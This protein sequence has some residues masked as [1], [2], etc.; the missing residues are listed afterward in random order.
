VRSRVET[1]YRDV[2]R[3]ADGSTTGFLQILVA[4]AQKNTFQRII[5][6]PIYPVPAKSAGLHLA[7]DQFLEMI[8]CSGAHVPTLLARI[9]LSVRQL[10]ERK[11]TGTF[12]TAASVAE[13][14]LAKGLLTSSDDVCDAGAGTGV[15]ADAILRNGQPIRSYVGVENDPVLALCAAHALEALNAPECYKLWYANFLL[16]G[17]TDFTA[18]GLAVPTAVIANP[19]FVRS[20]N[21]TGRARIRAAL[22]SS[23]GVSVPSLAGS[24]SYFISRAADL[25]GASTSVES[26]PKSRLLFFL[27]K[28]AA[29]AA[30]VQQ[31][32]DDLRR[33]HGWACRQFEIPNKQTGV[34]RHASNSLALFFLLEQVPPATAPR[35]RKSAPR[36]CLQDVVRIKRGISTGFNDFFVLTDEEVKRRKI[37]KKRL[38][39]VLPTRISIKTKRF[40]K[41]DWD[42]LRLSN[43]PCWLL[44]LP[45]G[46]IEN[47]EQAI[48]EYLKEGLRRGVHETPTAKAY[49]T[50]FSIPVPESPPDV[51][52]TYLFRGLPRF[53][54]NDAGVLNLTNILGGRFVSAVPEARRRELIVDSLNTQ[55]KHWMKAGRQYK[56]GLMKIEP[57]ELCRLPID[58][59]LLK[60]FNRKKPT[61][62]PRSLFD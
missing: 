1:L 11:R 58:S 46:E 7:V 35:S 14:A 23:L 36:A 61:A 25:A 20:S 30:H 54:L 43:H 53:I 50:W 16:L 8:H 45:R 37:P 51:F 10:K 32:L 48:Q 56:G 52:V 41:A 19:P 6:C 18:R 15:F 60:L 49:R 12:F 29:G 13:W 9:F 2:L 62:V 59:S 4:A 38:S 3:F 40:S 24:G 57:R 55:P 27:P 26:R 42:Q 22:K 17:K 39:E 31:L 34:D 28:E 33:A 5:S 44:T 21:L 47:F